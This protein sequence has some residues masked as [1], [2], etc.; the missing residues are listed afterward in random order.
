MP[1]RFVDVLTALNNT[2]RVIVNLQCF[3]TFRVC[4]FKD[5]TIFNKGPYCHRKNLLLPYNIYEL[6]MIYIIRAS[7]IIF[8]LFDNDLEVSLI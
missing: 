5:M 4:Y 7:N 3:Q 1:Y 2:N 8:S 6:G